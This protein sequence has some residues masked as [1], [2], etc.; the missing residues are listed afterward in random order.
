[1]DI[2][3]KVLQEIL[4][5]LRE[6]NGTIMVDPYPGYGWLFIDNAEDLR[7]LLHDPDAY[8]AKSYK[9]TVERFRAWREFFNDDKQCRGTTKRGRRCRNF[10]DVRTPEGFVPGISDRC[11]LHT[12]P[13]LRGR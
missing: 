10:V 1:M 2:D 12:V 7:L 8:L 5:R 9:V 6:V 13:T 11:D 4:N 3:L